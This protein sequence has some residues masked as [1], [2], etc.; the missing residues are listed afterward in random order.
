M[1]VSIHF[2]EP[3][4]HRVGSQVR[5]HFEMHNYIIVRRL[6]HLK[7]LFVKLFVKLFLYSVNDP[8]NMGLGTRQ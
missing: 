6:M 5:T 7:K 1:V 3:R 2:Q 8:F 4:R